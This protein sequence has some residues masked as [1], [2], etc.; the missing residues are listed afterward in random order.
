MEENQEKTY[1]FTNNYGSVRNNMN[2]AILDEE[3]FLAVKSLTDTIKNTQEYKEY[4]FQKEK[5]KRVPELKAQI[6]E[7]RA[8][9]Y[10]LQNS[11]QSDNLMEDAERLQRENADLLENPMV[12]DFLQA[13][14]EFCRMMQGVNTCIM[15]AIDFE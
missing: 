15:E 5:V 10:Q 2:I 1:D 11:A 3:L 4:Q 12:A 13:E 6:D 7:F 8:K 14:V 9:N